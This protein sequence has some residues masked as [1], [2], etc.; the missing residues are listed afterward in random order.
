[1]TLVQHHKSTVDVFGRSMA[2]TESGSGDTILFLHGNPTS[3]FLWRNVIPHL[4]SLGRCIAPDLIGMGDSDKLPDSGPDAY[5]F[6]QHRE[7]L[8]AFLDAIDVGNRVTLV[9]HDWGSALGFDWARRQPERVKGIAYMES[10]VTPR[11]WSD[12]PAPTQEMFRRLRSP[13]GERMVL[14]ENIFVEA[15]LPRMIQRKL[16]DEEMAEYRRPFAERGEGRR[17][18]LTFPRQIPVDGEPADVVAAV[19]A[20]S[21]WLSTSSVPKLFVNG[22]PGASLSGR[23]REF[24]RTFPNQTEVTVRGLH[25]LPEDSPHEIGSAV[26]TW[27]RALG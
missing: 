27:L 3:S 5:T 24:C 26:A 2:Y 25:F 6:A 16:S 10:I 23:L 12:W 22:D 15:L 9:V 19:E 11:R 7:Y 14:D 17:P 1:M 20:Y 18:T 21:R 13:E 8:S 4:E